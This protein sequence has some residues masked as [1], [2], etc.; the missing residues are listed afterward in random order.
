M[1]CRSSSPV[2]HMQLGLRTIA[3]DLLTKKERTMSSKGSPLENW[4]QGSG[5]SP[6]VDQMSSAVEEPG[7]PGLAKPALA[8]H[9]HLPGLTRV[10]AIFKNNCRILGYG[11]IHKAARQEKE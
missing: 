11:Y 3:L 1:F 8:D 4:G 10:N 2:V 7:S 6:D 5:L 9:S